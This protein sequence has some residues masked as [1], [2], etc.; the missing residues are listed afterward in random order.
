MK[1]LRVGHVLD[2]N[3]QRIV[4]NLRCGVNV[5]IVLPLEYIPIASTITT[6]DPLK[7]YNKLLIH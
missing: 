7:T 4:W 1:L 3:I 6:T 5:H 2:M